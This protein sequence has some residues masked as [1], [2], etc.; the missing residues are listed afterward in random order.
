MSKINLND[1]Q[2][3]DNSPK[4]FNN[5]IAGKVEGVTLSVERKPTGDTSNIPDY[6]LIATDDREAS[7]NVGFY[8]FSAN[9]RKNEKENARSQQLFLSRIVSLAKA[10]MGEEY[11][12]PEVETAKEALDFIMRLVSENAGTKK[13][14]VYVTYGTTTRPSQYLGLRYFDFIE[15]ANTDPKRSKL[16]RKNID[17]M[18]Q[19]TP[20]NTL[21]SEE[22]LVD[23]IGSLNNSNLDF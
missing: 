11:E 13:F 21:Q 20:D 7:V 23:S 22:G 5:G 10:V 1:R 17:L 6:K 2:F 19:L 15:P 4:I 3:V 8:H 18:E 9:P 16:V 12:L 14:N